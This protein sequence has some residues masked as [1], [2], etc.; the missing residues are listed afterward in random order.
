MEGE[1]NHSSIHTYVS[2]FL[3]LIDFSLTVL[4]KVESLLQGKSSWKNYTVR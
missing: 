2:W 3:V 4:I 1:L